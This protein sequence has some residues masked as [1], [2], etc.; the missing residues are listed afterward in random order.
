MRKIKF[1]NYF[2][3]MF[4]IIFAVISCSAEK[5][6]IVLEEKWSSD[7]IFKVP[8]SVNYD[9][10][11]NII[12]VSNIC[13]KPSEKDGN[14]FI[15]QIKLNG[16]IKNLKWITGLNAPKGGSVYKNKFYVSDIDELIEIDIERGKVANKYKIEE[17]IFLNDVVTD[18][19]GNV[20]ISDM[21]SRNSII[22][23]FTNGKISKWIECKE[24][25]SPN[26][27]CILNNKLFVGNSGDGKIKSIDLK[28]KKIKEIAE[29][30]SGIDGL[31]IDNSRNIFISDWQGR[32]SVVKKS[33][34]IKTL[35]N[36]TDE[37]IN[38]ADI[39]LIP[40]KNLLFI[41]TFFDNRIIC[42]D[43]K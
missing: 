11:N 32:T 35:I 26:G 39:E 6:E 22:Y 21:S 37:K 27:L 17:A 20:Y 33:D 34:K 30:G 13:G 12:Y 40:E 41:P 42:Y 14:G 18:D 15:S 28:T 43:V 10:A 23:K 31:K 4:I 29:I 2:I 8:E 19:S 9:K 3:S 1:S 16:E 7:R 38:S 5:N 36:T 24:I 25:L